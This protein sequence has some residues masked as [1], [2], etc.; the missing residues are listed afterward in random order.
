MGR[1]AARG[2]MFA[3]RKGKGGL[4]ARSVGDLKGWRCGSITWCCLVMDGSYSQ[5][6]CN[7]NWSI[8]IIYAAGRQ[9]SNDFLLSNARVS[10]FFFR[11]VTI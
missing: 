2:V 5:F 9:A 1:F 11:P 7:V 3:R 6:V 8:E 10:A 4:C